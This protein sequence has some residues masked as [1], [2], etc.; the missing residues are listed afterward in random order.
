MRQ[1]AY[2]KRLLER[3]RNGDHPRGITLIL[4]DDWTPAEAPWPEMIALKPQDWRP[5]GIDWLVVSGLPVLM[6]ERLGVRAEGEWTAALLLSVAA[7]VAWWA[8]RV[9]FD[10]FPTGDD[11]QLT[12]LCYRYPKD[13]NFWW[14]AWW[15][16][17]QEMRARTNHE[18][19]MAELLAEQE[20]G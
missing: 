19:W 2:A 15:S 20:A 13:R 3:R 16:D 7:E 6:V 14:P 4:G 10:T 5:K 12:A 1:P 17:A 18:R 9:Y 11:L 8:A